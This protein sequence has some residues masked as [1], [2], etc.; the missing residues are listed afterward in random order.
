MVL[1][2]RPLR[3]KADKALSCIHVLAVSGSIGKGLLPGL[4]FLLFVLERG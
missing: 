3:V 1:G 4:V 2:P